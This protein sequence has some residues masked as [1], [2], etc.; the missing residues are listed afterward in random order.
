M[1]METNKALVRRWAEEVLSKGNLNAIDELFASDYVDH[2]NPPDWP[3]GREGHK[4]I[5]TL[6][7]AAFPDFLYTVEHEVAEGDMVAVRG[8]YH[9]THQGAFFGIAPTGT[10]ITTTGMHLFRI[11]EGRIAEHWCNNDDLGVM[12]QLGV[13]AE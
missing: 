3:L 5:V 10:Q 4:Q 9:G 6:Y 7:H 12:R 8:T 13:L 2:T 11:A 1:S